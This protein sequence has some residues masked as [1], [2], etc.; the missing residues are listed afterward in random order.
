M[1]E[2]QRFAEAW[3]TIHKKDSNQLGKKSD[4]V[5]ETYVQWIID[6]AMSYGMPYT[7]PRLLT[8]DRAM[9]YGMP[10]TLRLKRSINA[11]CM[12]PIVSVPVGK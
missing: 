7:L 8:I 5:H 11:V 10:Y 3:K 12:R 1:E 4:F 6:R 2:S 9:S